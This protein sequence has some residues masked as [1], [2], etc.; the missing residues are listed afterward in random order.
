MG[1]PRKKCT[2]CIVP[3]RSTCAIASCGGV[4]SGPGNKINMSVGWMALEGRRCVSLLALC[5]STS[6]ARFL[7]QIHNDRQAN[8]SYDSRLVYC[9]GSHILW[10]TI[11][12]GPC[13][14]IMPFV[15]VQSSVN[16]RQ[17]MRSPVPFEC[18]WRACGNCNLPCTCYFHPAVANCNKC[19]T[20]CIEWE[21]LA[22]VFLQVQRDEFYLILTSVNLSL[23]ACFYYF[24]LLFFWPTKR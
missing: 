1:T 9:T 13:F 5:K 2:Q 10:W 24:F 11:S 7:L 14:L 8:H 21:L 6:T 15:C 17:H 3:H 4:S 18:P 16:N 20:Y 19:I 23:L 12:N 22:L